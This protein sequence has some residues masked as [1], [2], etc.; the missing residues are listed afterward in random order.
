MARVIEVG[1][2]EIYTYNEILDMLMEA[3]GKRRFKAPGP[4]P[5]VE[6]GCQRDERA[7]RQTANH[8]SGHRVI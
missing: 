3:L 6:P 1:G 7:A 5:I 8:P 4:K 2:P